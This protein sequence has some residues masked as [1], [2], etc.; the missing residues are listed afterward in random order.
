M[1]E[2]Q[3]VLEAQIKK[4]ADL[5]RKKRVIEEARIDRDYQNT[6]DGQ[7]QLRLFKELDL[8]KDDPEKVEKII[9]E[10]N[11]YIKSAKKNMRFIN[12]DFDGIVPFHANNI[13]LV[14]AVTGQGK[15]TITAN[16]CYS[17]LKQKKRVLVISNEEKSGDV[18]NRVTCLINGWGYNKHS[19]ISDDQLEVFGKYT[20][21]MRNNLRVVDNDS[22]NISGL[23]SS[24]EGITGLL[25]SLLGKPA[26]Y[27]AIL[28]DYYQNVNI[29]SSNPSAE[30]WKAQ[31]KF[32]NF[33]D[34]FKGKYP[35]PIVLMAQ[36][37]GRGKDNEVEFK[38]RIEGRKSVLNKCTFAFEVMADKKNR[39][40]EWTI[41]KQRFGNNVGE[42]F[43][44]GWDLGKYVKYDK[45]FQLKVQDLMLKKMKGMV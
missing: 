45:E 26:I 42:S 10:A 4:D 32:V 34:D 19:E 18:Y 23:T 21:A 36:M 29:L 25:N 15:S 33:L 40:T 9:K 12:E 13:V 5:G 24:Y 22:E 11:D 6:V 7:N 8:S 37:K 35:A 16:I 31:E 30:P 27:D 1:S 43:H 41:H 14:A 39:R 28:I 2:Q 20:R 38:D 44:T 17:L 3:K